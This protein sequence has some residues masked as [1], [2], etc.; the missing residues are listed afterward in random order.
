MIEDFHFLR[1]AWL[2]AILAAAA[3]AWLIARRGDVRSRWGGTIAP[4]LLA[5]L[6][7]DRRGNVRIRP[8]HLT[9]ALIVL[10]AIAAAGPTWDRERAPFVED[11][12][13]LAIAIDLSQTM[14]ATDVAPTRI[15]RVKLKVRDLLTRRQGARTAIFA[16]AGSAH[17][18]L[19]LT[20]DASLI[21][22]Y[23]DSLATRIMPVAGK[24]TV[25]A[26]HLAEAALAHEDVPGTILFMTDGVEPQA[27]EAFKGTPKRNEIMVLGVGTAAGGPVKIGDG[28][29][30]TDAGGQRVFSRLDVDALRKLKSQTGVQLATI[31]LDDSDVDWIE[32]RV[33]THLQEQQ[34]NEESRWRDCGWWLT[35]PIAMLSALWFR[36]G[37]TIRWVSVVLIAFGLS[38]SGQHPAS[39]ADWRLSDPWRTQ[40]QQGRRAFDRG[41]YAGA[42]AHFED[43]MWKGIALYRAGRFSEA[44]EALAPLDTAESYYNQGNAQAHLGRLPQAVASYTQALKRR[45]DW[46]EAKANLDI[47]QAVIALQEK[48]EN[49]EQTLTLEKDDMADSVTVDER[50]KKGKKGLVNG[51]QQSAEMWMRNIQ[52]T[53]ADL[54][55]RK[56][57]IEADGAKP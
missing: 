51:G 29:F 33:Q 52:V 23:V 8:V 46:P 14:D 54:L 56:F 9:V 37:W 4:Q 2:F 31:T 47:I 21:Q 19:P 57:A 26:L 45:P 16:Y 17:M 5:H 50:G 49:E 7:I 35:I 1:P 43:P 38:L 24:D 12:A 36:R 15:E 25:K 55:A 32:R 28:E 22:T 39:A 20:D 41:D 44:I 3:L 6:L 30:L 48:T 42:A 10:G 13:P 11:K 27:T 18:V 40:D 53:P 34:A